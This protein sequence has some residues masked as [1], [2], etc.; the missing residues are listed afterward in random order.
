MG[1]FDWLQGLS[2]KHIR[3]SEN[4]HI[5]RQLHAC[6][7]FQILGFRRKE[8]KLKSLLKVSLAVLKSFRFERGQ[9]K[10]GSNINGIQDQILSQTSTKT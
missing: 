1:D 6:S 10:T 5:H 2:S 7:F 3:E 9:T 4:Y 8:K